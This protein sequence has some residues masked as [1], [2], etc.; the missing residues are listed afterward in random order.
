MKTKQKVESGKQKAA[1]K[2]AVEPMLGKLVE[3]KV[4]ELRPSKTNPRKVFREEFIK[5][6]ADSIRVQGVLQPLVVRKQ[7]LV[8]YEI[9]MGEQRFRAS[10][11][12]GLGYVPCVVKEMTDAE[13]LE[14]QLIENLQR[15][16]LGVLEEAEQ[17]AKLV[18]SKDYTADSLAERLGKSRSHVYGRLRMASLA[19]PAK[20]ALANGR[21]LPTVAGLIAAVPGVEAQKRLVA[22]A[23]SGDTEGDGYVGDG[24]LSFRAVKEWIEQEFA[25]PLSKAPFDPEEDAGKLYG[26]TESGRPIGACTGCAFRSGNLPI[27]GGEVFGNAN[28]CTRVMCF[29]AKAADALARKV[30]AAKAKGTAVIE[31]QQWRREKYNGK[32]ATPESHMYEL[33]KETTVKQ[34]VKQLGD[35]APEPMLAVD[36][37]KLVEVYP[38]EELVEAARGKGLVAEASTQETEANRQER[39]A[40]EARQ[41][42]CRG[43]EA[44]VLE[45]MQEGPVDG[46]WLRK[47]GLAVLA[48]APFHI[49]KE[50]WKA[51]ALDH[52]W[53]SE[54]VSGISAE[55]HVREM[56]AKGDEKRVRKLVCQILL[57]A[58]MFWANWRGELPA[59][60]LELLKVAGV[61]AP[62]T[63]KV[64]AGEAE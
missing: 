61:E 46:E 40:I 18:A 58:P 29:E 35:A 38:A 63:L 2:P 56:L 6:L 19:G 25:R 33:K 7:D 21:L 54:K 9:V 22:G 3:L 5:E 62:A 11:L 39:E 32:Y 27:G 10:K 44:K 49:N 34:L 15:A 17:M 45:R 51:L 4:A 14:A 47:L 26:L 41:A 16:D 37:G 43:L 31:E 23:I 55:K 42:E 1:I 57:P 12:A 53:V 36:D 8:T 50:A 24:P 20:E 13:V 60:D 64:V 59:R 48:R 28:V 30:K 52:C